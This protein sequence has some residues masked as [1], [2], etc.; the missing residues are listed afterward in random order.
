M[1]ERPQG[2]DRALLV[3]LDL[4]EGSLEERLAE[5]KALAL[6]PAPT[7]TGVDHRAAREARSGAVRRQRQGRRDRGATRS[8]TDADLVI[9]DHYAVRGA[10]AQSRT[11][12]RVP[13]RR[14]R[15]PDPR[16]LRAARAKRRRQAAGRAGAACSTCRRGWSAAGPTSS[17][18]QGGIGLARP[19]RDPARDRPP[20]DRRTRQAA[21]RAA[22]R[23][24]RASARRSAARG[25]APRSAT[26]RWS[27][28]PTPANRRCSIA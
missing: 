23:R 26:S 24:S 20:P 5:L 6:R 4:G 14:S 1:L 15:Q 7:V 17:V 19:R 2:G 8:E 11:R 27:A 28:T 16:Y 3:E 13:R 18:R 25:V 12:A 10:A 9:F 21:A 22:W